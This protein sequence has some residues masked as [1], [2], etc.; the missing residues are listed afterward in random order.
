M[1]AIEVLLEVE[2]IPV[3]DLGPCIG[4]LN[5]RQT[6]S[7]LREQGFKFVIKTSKFEVKDQDGE[8]CFPGVYFISPEDKSIVR[9]AL[10]NYVASEWKKAEATSS[11]NSAPKNN[12]RGQ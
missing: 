1:R 11:K 10:R 4:A 5:A 6:I 2:S 7:E 9:E 8:S 3:K 12:R